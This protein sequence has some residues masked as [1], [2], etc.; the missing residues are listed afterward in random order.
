MSGLIVFIICIVLAVITYRK[1]S[2]RSRNKGWGKFRTLTLSLLMSFIVFCVSLGIGAGVL[3][4][5]KSTDAKTS[6]AGSP[7]KTKSNVYKCDKFDAIT[8]TRQGTKNDSGYYSDKGI[9]IEYTVSDDKLIMRMPIPNDKDSIYIGTFNKIA[10]DGSRKYGNSSANY[11]VSK[12]ND[13]TIKVITVNFDVQ[14]TLTQIC[15]K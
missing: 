2:N 7:E 10:A 4:E 14:M 12:L 13:S 3:S 15:S 9:L 6:A 5:D 1:V 11:F 8:Q